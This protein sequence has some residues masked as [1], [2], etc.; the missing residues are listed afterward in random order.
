MARLLRNLADVVE[1][2]DEWTVDGEGR[3]PIHAAILVM[4][5]AEGEPTPFIPG[6]SGATWAD[7]GE[8]VRLIADASES[9]H[10]LRSNAGKCDDDSRYVEVQRRWR[11]RE[12]SRQITRERAAEAKE[13]TE[14]ER[15]WLCDCGFRARSEG[16]LTSHRRQSRRHRLS[17]GSGTIY[18]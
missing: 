12:Q 7:H 10:A 11:V 2:G 17:P 6:V 14:R 13:Q 8:W 3:D 5:D 15:P 9:V 1:S 4:F 18:T 16:G